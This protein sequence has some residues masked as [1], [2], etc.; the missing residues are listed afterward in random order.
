MVG[1][2][3]CFIQYSPGIYGKSGIS[4]AVS[5]L[6]IICA[7]KP[8]F[9]CCGEINTLWMI[10]FYL[11]YQYVT[12]CWSF[13]FVVF[14]RICV[15][16]NQNLLSDFCHQDHL[17]H[18]IKIALVPRWENTLWSK[19]IVTLIWD[20]NMSHSVVWWFC[21][22]WSSAGLPY[23]WTRISWGTSIIDIVSA[24]QLLPWFWGETKISWSYKTMRHLICRILPIRWILFIC[25][26]HQAFYIENPDIAKFPSSASSL[27]SDYCPKSEVR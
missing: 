11:W 14:T 10:T 21:I 7:V 24:I 13:C 27:P 15:Q 16:E 26:L 18:P 5:D 22:L 25:V 4:W 6:A 19:R 9:W 12:F 23:K 8:F 17:S 3:F 2:Y 1:L 20:I